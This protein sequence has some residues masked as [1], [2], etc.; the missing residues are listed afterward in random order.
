MDQ[1]LLKIHQQLCVIKRHGMALLNSYD[2]N[3]VCDIVFLLER[4]RG[5]TPKQQDHCALIVDRIVR[6]GAL[7]EQDD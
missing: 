3:F 5:L 2:Q 6:T 7:R 4:G 1:N